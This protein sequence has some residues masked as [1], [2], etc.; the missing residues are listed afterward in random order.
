MTH[1]PTAPCD[2]PRVRWFAEDRFGMF[3]H[4]GLYSNPAGLWQGRRMK[5]PYAEWL[6]GSEPITRAEY[7]RLA[8]QF[9]PTGFDAERWVRDA[10]GAGMR[11]G[12]H[13]ARSTT[14]GATTASTMAGSPLTSF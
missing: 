3:I 4:W 1:S 11:Y 12:R 9:N 10:K 13:R 8:E 14:P 5:H 2:D 7:R 6:Q